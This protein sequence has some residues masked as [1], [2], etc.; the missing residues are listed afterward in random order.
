MP[1]CLRVDGPPPGIQPA[2][3]ANHCQEV[4]QGR[5]LVTGLLTLAGK[6][7]PA[8][9]TD[10]CGNLVL[11]AAWLATLATEEP[12]TA[13]YSRWNYPA[14]LA[15]NPLF[16]R[17]NAIITAVWGEAFLFMAVTALGTAFMPEQKPLWL[18]LRYIPLILA[19]LFTACF[20]TGTRPM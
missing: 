2:V 1:L 11:G 15:T 5:Q 4:L 12:L 10:F 17:T 3:A 16:L 9:A 7:L 13:A 20:L 19:G 8:V 18:T 6:A 14:G